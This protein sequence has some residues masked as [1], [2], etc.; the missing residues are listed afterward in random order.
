MIKS[1][2]DTNNFYFIYKKELTDFP[3]ENNPKTSKPPPFSMYLCTNKSLDV[4]LLP[5]PLGNLLSEAVTSE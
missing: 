4:A 5:T 1:L 3:D 2:A